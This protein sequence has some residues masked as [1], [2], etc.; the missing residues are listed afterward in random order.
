MLKKIITN[1]FVW[2]GVIL[3]TLFWSSSTPYSDQSIQSPLARFSWTWLEPALESLH[4]SYGDS[5][6][7]LETYETVGVIEFLL[8]KLAHFTIFLALG[9]LLVK[10]VGRLQLALGLTM[11][12]AWGLA[13]TVAVFDEFHQSLTPERTPLIQDVV[14][15]STGALVGIMLGAI[16]LRRV[17]ERHRQTE[18]SYLVRPR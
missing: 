2:I 3:L 10:A 6:V 7:S 4:F 14:L 13:N 17:R 5:V 8:R 15:D 11:L 9:A 1:E 16:L 12:F 18:D